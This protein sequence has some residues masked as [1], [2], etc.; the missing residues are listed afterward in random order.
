MLVFITDMYEQHEEITKLL[1][2][3]SSLKHDII[4]FHLMGEN[5]L[6][7]NFGNYT[8]VQ[9]LETG[10]KISINTIETKKIYE[11]KL[12]QH[13]SGVRMRLLEKHIFYRMINM[14]EPLDKS[15]RDF[16]TQRQKTIV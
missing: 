9:D 4:V 16:L 1:G 2:T 11:Q 13:L 6:T 5:E 12:Q 10:E 7:L 3:L 14:A 15:L 8:A